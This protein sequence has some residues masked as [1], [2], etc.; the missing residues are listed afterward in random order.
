MNE[1]YKDQLLCPSIGCKDCGEQSNLVFSQTSIFSFSFDSRL[2]SKKRFC[3]DLQFITADKGS[4]KGGGAWAR[5]QK[6]PFP[7][8]PSYPGGTLFVVSN[9]Q[10]H[11]TELLVF[12]IRG[13]SRSE[14]LIGRGC[15]RM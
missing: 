10:T 3:L 15:L 4:N 13:R 1:T 11:F 6:H 2:F 9:K 14:S 8:P 12:G 5:G 7:K